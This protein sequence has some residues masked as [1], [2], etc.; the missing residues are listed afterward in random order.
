MKKGDIYFANLANACPGESNVEYG[1]R[2]V[3]LYNNSASLKYSPIVTVLPLT[4]KK[5]DIYPEHICIN[6]SCLSSGKIKPSYILTEHIR[7][8]DKSC[9]LFKVGHLSEKYLNQV[10]ANVK[11][12]L[13]MS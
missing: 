6:S 5:K 3:I 4:S 11:H 13:A 12:L 9:L 2:P 10:D 8:V 1:T 7:T